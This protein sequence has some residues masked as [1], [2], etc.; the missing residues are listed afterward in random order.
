M[1]WRMAAFGSKADID[2]PL[3]YQSRFMSTR[4]RHGRPQAIDIEALDDKG[5]ETEIAWVQHRGRPVESA[6]GQQIATRG[7]GPKIQSA[8]D[9]DLRGGPLNINP[10]FLPK[11]G[12]VAVVGDSNIFLHGS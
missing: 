11:T 7:G 3:L 6:P 10:Y 1:R 4:P 2:Q 8:A 9:R 12:Q 5:T